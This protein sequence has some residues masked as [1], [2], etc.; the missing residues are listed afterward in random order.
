MA[1]VVPQGFLG[2][3]FF[4]LVSPRAL[5]EVLLALAKKAYRYSKNTTCISDIKEIYLESHINCRVFLQGVPWFRY[6]MWN[7]M[8]VQ[9]GGNLRHFPRQNH[10][11]IYHESCIWDC[12]APNCYDR[13]WNINVSKGAV[14]F[15]GWVVFVNWSGGV[16]GRDVAAKGL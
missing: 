2:E 10:S 15:L 8:Q 7:K 16:S 5:L 13:S 11:R 1:N 14:H 12:Q 9:R 4:T 6:V 3:T